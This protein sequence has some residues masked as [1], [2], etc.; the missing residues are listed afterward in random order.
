MILI[1]FLFW[2]PAHPQWPIT[3]FPWL[4]PGGGGLGSSVPSECPSHKALCPSQSQ[5]STPV[6]AQG[7]RTMVHTPLRSPHTNGHSARTSASRVIH[8]LRGKG[9]DSVRCYRVTWS[10]KGDAVPAWRN[11][12]PQDQHPREQPGLE[13]VGSEDPSSQGPDTG[14]TARNHWRV[15]RKVTSAKNSV[16]CQV[17]WAQGVGG[18]WGD[19]STHE[20]ESPRRTGLWQRR[21]QDRKWR[22]QVSGVPCSSSLTHLTGQALTITPPLQWGRPSTA[23]RLP[24]GP[25]GGEAP[26]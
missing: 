16:Q 2:K 17:C 20:V 25:A 7:S 23:N 9:Q 21:W 24:P 18:F 26:V 14:Q 11:Q 5:F 12:E 15:D 4:T 6:G 13:T 8:T 10:R 22:E 3:S 1:L 19:S